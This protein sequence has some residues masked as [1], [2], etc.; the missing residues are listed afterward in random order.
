MGICAAL[1][2]LAR[3]G[4][5]VLVTGHSVEDLLQLADDVIWMVGGTTHHVGTPAQAR[6]HFQL[7]KDYLGGRVAS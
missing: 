1:R 2:A 7:R 5:G 6:A 3:D 4:A